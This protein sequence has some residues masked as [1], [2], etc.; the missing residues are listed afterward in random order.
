MAGRSLQ[1]AGCRVFH[2][3]TD[4]WCHSGRNP[5][6]FSQYIRVGLVRCHMTHTLSAETKEYSSSLKQGK[7]FPYK[8]IS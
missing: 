4:L 6:P 1:V 7:I 2:L 5:V 8:V 3:C